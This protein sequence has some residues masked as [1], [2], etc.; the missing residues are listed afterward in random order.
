MDVPCTCITVSIK[1]TI[2]QVGAIFKNTLKV[3]G[4]SSTGLYKKVMQSKNILFICLHH[5][6]T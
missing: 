2:I 4:R 5:L 3:D 6:G 1:N